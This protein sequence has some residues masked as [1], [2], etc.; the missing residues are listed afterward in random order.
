M[1]ILLFIPFYN[2]EKQIGRVL[3]Q[4]LP[5]THLFS[6]ILCVDNQSSDNSFESAISACKHLQLKNVTLVKN[7]ENVNLGG[8]HKVAFDYADK[9]QFDYVVV[10]HGDDQGS[11]RDLIP[12]IESSTHQKFDCL[13]GARFHKESKLQGYSKFRTF[14]N[15]VLNAFCSLAVR[16][17]VQDMGSGLN[18]YKA[19]F[20][21]DKRIRQFP[22]DLTFNVFLLFHS[23]FNKN[24]ILYFPITWR[25]ED[26]VSNA[27][28][29]KQ[30]KKIVLLVLK[31]VFRPSTL[32]SI[33]ST[34]SYTYDVKF[35]S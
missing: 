17:W 25:D 30:F 35:Q 27:K 1:K 12:L 26:Q 28:L 3:K 20:F 4:V 8:S 10:L 23:Y 19:S 33:N 9:H 32:Y 13:L 22:D 29:F 16:G 18:M 34:K 5:Y 7:N 31:T 21:K 14:G 15:I 24:S 6:A 2:C 11:L